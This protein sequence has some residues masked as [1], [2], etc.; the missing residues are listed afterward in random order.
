MSAP[1]APRPQLVRLDFRPGSSLSW[2]GPA[3]AALAGAMA[4]HRLAP[5]AD[6]LLIL[7]VALLL[8]DPLLGG[9][10]TVVTSADWLAPWRETPSS[11]TL[12]PPLPH[13]E[14]GSPAHRLS[15]WL[16]RLRGHGLEESPRGILL[17][18]TEAGF[19]LVSASAL[20][21][22]LG[23]PVILVVIAAFSLAMLCA[24]LGGVRRHHWLETAY[25]FA[26][27]WLV[28]YGAFGGLPLEAQPA[29]LVALALGAAAALA[30]GGYRTLVVGGP[31][32]GALLALD[33]G[34]LLALVV[35][36]AA[37]RPWQAGLAGLLLVAQALWQPRLWRDRDPLSY[38][39][40]TQGFLALGVLACFLQ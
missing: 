39:G 1:A 16:A 30:Y 33:L 18:L 24:L 32:P 23:P 15:E 9:L 29:S 12:P 31:L 26:V 20:A 38:A 17:P 35:L 27:P 40:A 34:Q 8:A 7:V 37:Q 19:Y 4:S 13:A 5:D 14:A 36:V 11:V 28:G 10:W 22:V 2:V 6:T 3:L 25:V 21:A